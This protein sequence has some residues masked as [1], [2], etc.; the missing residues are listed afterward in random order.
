MAVK[1][2]AGSSCITCSSYGSTAESVA[3]DIKD[4]KQKGEMFYCCRGQCIVIDKITT[5][6]TERDIP[7]DPKEPDDPKKPDFTI[8]DL[9][10]KI[11]IERG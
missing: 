7:D 11:Y 2:C 3:K 6:T 5:V 1:I 10:I 9:P 8:P 4:A